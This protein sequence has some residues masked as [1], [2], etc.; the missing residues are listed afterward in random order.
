MKV[1]ESIFYSGTLFP[2]NNWRNG[3]AYNRDA[4][5]Q[6]VA[7]YL[8]V[9]THNTNKPTWTRSDGPVSDKAPA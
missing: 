2:R 8:G 7:G 9:V 1:C 5:S 6:A 4:K 3:H